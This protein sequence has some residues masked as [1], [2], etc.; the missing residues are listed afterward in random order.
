MP[1]SSKNS[2]DKN[3]FIDPMEKEKLI[4]A[5][6]SKDIYLDSLLQKI[7]KIHSEG[8]DYRDYQA[9]KFK[10]HTKEPELRWDRMFNDF[11]FEVYQ[12]FEREHENIYSGRLLEKIK[13]IY[14]EGDDHH[15]I[16]SKLYKN[17]PK[18]E[19]DEMFQDFFVNIYLKFLQ[20]QKNF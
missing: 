4:T 17:E 8:G 14:S 11:F 7:Q 19:H 9:I 20:E 2:V 1:E 6:K 10:L 13:N 5:E 3:L 18:L 12:K 16:K 15:N